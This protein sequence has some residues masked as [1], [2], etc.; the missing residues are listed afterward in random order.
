[1][2]NESSLNEMTKVWYSLIDRIDSVKVARDSDVSDLRHV[3]KAKNPSL[4]DVDPGMIE[5]YPPVAA[6]VKETERHPIRL[7]TVLSS[8]ETS[9]DRPLEV[10]APKSSVRITKARTCFSFDDSL[11]KPFDV[12]PPKSTKPEFVAPDGWLEEVEVE[13]VAQLQRSED[14]VDSDTDD[15]MGDTENDGDETLYRVAPMAVVRC[16]RGGKTRALYEIANKMHGYN[17]LCHQNIASLYISFND[18]S[19]LRPWE[20]EDPLQ[21]L[22]R[23]IVFMAS[24]N[25]GKKRNNGTFDDFVN[26]KQY[27]DPR[28][29][30]E[31]LGD[32][33]STPC[34]LIVDELNNLHELSKDNSPAAAEFARFLKR[35]FIASPN[36]YLVFSSHKVSTLEFFSLFVDPCGSVRPVVL[37][38]LP[39][40][41]TLFKA[42]KLKPDLDSAREAIYYGLLPGLIYESTETRSI[43]GKRESLTHEFLTDSQNLDKDFRNILRSLLSGDSKLVPKPLLML[44]DSAGNRDGPSVIRW[45]PFHLS[46]VLS[47]LA[48]ADSF[49]DKL[50]ADHMVKLCDSIRDSKRY[51]GE[52]W[53]GIFVLFLL[54]RC[55]TDSCDEYFVPSKWFVEKPKVFFNGPYQSNER[56]LFSACKNWG[57][58][59]KSVTPGTEPQ[60]SIL[61]P[62]HSRFATYDVLA[63]HSKDG[64]NK[65]I[66]GYQL[67]EGT[68]SIAH[69]A[70]IDIERSFWIQ[71]KSPKNAKEQDNWH[72][73]DKT[74]VDKFYG[75][76]G[77]HWTPE[78]WREF[79]A[80]T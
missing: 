44:L 33:Q 56:R 48:T 65:S 80:T 69:P 68:A 52:G 60:L 66:Y 59:L 43:V 62:T 27:I 74:I 30:L 55:L 63:V 15:Y 17:Q 35:D 20:Q 73:P 3:I 46:Y 71:G 32:S 31:W 11:P 1:M 50:I 70:T 12:I 26:K 28:D 7:D 18:Y 29:F 76:S 25:G 10:V 23:R 6:V 2:A 37:Q 8:L 39:I 14:L 5:I 41:D 51:S 77:E 58:L 21:A 36:R 47:R 45:V 19:S 54:A 64:Q 79:E 24:H 34:V 40:T 72:I 4:K 78:Q 9:L 22:L 53:E 67:K 49:S 61:F 38:E 16:S 57:H 42:L 13:I 75:A